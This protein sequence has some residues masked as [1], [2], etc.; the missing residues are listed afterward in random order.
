M[1]HEPG[2]N[3]RVLNRGYEGFCRVSAG[4]T[5]FGFF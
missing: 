5:G 3:Q 2:D 1:S 4:K